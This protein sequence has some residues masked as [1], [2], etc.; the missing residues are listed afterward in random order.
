MSDKS[1][2]IGLQTVEFLITKAKIDVKLRKEEL[3]K[4]GVVN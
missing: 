4:I 3:K 1:R 2:S